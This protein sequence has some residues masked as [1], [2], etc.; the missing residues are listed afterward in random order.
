MPCKMI[1][2]SVKVG[3]CC[4]C[5]STSFFCHFSRFPPPPSI[6]PFLLPSPD[7]RCTRPTET[8]FPSLITIFSAPNYLDMYGNKGEGNH[9]HSLSIPLA[10]THTHAHTH[11]H[12]HTHCDV[13][14]CIYVCVRVSYGIEVWCVELCIHKYIHEYSNMS[15]RIN[16]GEKGKTL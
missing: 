16:V 12:T 2:Y 5:M 8:R 14:I 6:P 13:C 15:M 10:I 9:V 4:V 7:T 11:T 1:A 3:H